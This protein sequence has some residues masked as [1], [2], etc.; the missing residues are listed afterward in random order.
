MWGD[1]GR[2]RGH[3]SR[4]PSFGLREV[5]VGAVVPSEVVKTTAWIGVAAGLGVGAG[6]EEI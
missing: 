6:L 1:V 5:S 3:T 4:D 2:Y